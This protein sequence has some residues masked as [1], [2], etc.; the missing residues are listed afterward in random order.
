MP[1]SFDPVRRV[2]YFNTVNVGMKIKYVKQERPKQPTWYLG[3][4]LGGFVGPEDGL[5]G[6]LVAWDPVAGKKIWEMPS[7]SPNWAGVVSTAG[8][9]LFTGAQTGEFMAFDAATGKKLWQFQTG[10]GI[11]GLPIVWERG[12]KQYVTVTSGAATVYGA[13]AGDPEL[14]NMSPGSSLWTFALRE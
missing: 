12:G 1:M 7:K 11:S 9:V 14:A 6:S 5:R 2:A 10:S 8:G 4:E 3:L 13:L